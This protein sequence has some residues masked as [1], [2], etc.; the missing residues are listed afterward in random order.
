MVLQELKPAERGL[1]EMMEDL[2]DLMRLPLKEPA[3]HN[4]CQGLAAVALASPGISPGIEKFCEDIYKQLVQHLG[5]ICRVRNSLPM[6]N[7]T[8][9]QL[10]PAALAQ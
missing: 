3:L 5:H 4:M 1:E 8:L 6:L 9:A 7:H 2:S 10:G